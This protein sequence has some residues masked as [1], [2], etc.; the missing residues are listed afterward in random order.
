MTRAADNPLY[1]PT[2]ATVDL[3]ALAHN[4]GVLK[5]RLPSRVAMMAMVKADAYGHGAVQVS[6]VLEE[7]GVRALGVATVE[8]G[9]ELREAGIATQIVV[10]GGLMGMGSPASRKM[11]EANLTP[12]IHS[13]G[14]LPSLEEDAARAGKKISVHLKVDTGMSRLGMRP[15]VLDAVLARLKECPH[16]A[17]EGVMTH[18]AEADHADI[19]DRQMDV[20]LACRRRIEEA[21]GPIR[22]WHIANSA[23]MLRGMPV[24]IP[25]AAEVWARPGLALYGD[26]NGLHFAGHELTPVMGLESRAVLTKRVP[27]GARVS[28]G[29]TFTTRRP[30]RLAIVP[31]GYAD[32]YPWKVSGQAQV[33]THGQRVPVVGRVTMDMIVI[34]VTDVA[35]LNVGDE[36][37]LLGRQGREQITLH[38]IAS[39]ADTITYEI[40]CGIS[41]RMPRVYREG[42]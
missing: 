8:E 40:L 41:K 25:D 27:E 14:V 29:G 1:R 10:M 16:L 19:S 42:S 9:I 17:V 26:I 4:Y 24:D 37:V 36:V 39:W 18:L 7:Q 11:V 2:W 3:A 35:G 21:L 13:T 28:Y 34:D 32:G 5:A 30:S 20:F 6:R 12:V 31:I 38:D 33:L 15:E 22:I 23:A